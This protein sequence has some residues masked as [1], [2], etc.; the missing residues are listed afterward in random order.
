MSRPDPVDAILSAPAP[1][2]R[3]QARVQWRHVQAMLDQGVPMADM[4]GPGLL[5]FGIVRI[6]GREMVVTEDARL[7]AYLTGPG[8]FAL[9]GVE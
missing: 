4:V 5:K 8:L 9:P 7:R 3:A 1:M 6:G 2:Y